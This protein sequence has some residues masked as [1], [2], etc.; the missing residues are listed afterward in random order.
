MKKI[1]AILLALIMASSVALVSCDDSSSTDDEGPADFDGAFVDEDDDEGDGSDEV[2]AEEDGD[3]ENAGN[4]SNSTTMENVNDTVYLLYPAKIREKASDK[5]SV[6]SLAN[7]PFG[8]TLA[9]TSK[10]SKWS[11]VTYTENGTSYT[12]YVPNDLIST[13][14]NSIKFDEKKNE[15]GSE[16]VTAIK[17]NLG[18]GI[19][20]A[21]IRKYPLANGTPNTFNVVDKDEFN[22]K[23]IV[24]QIA[25]NTQNITLVSVSADGVWAKVKGTGVVFENGA[26]TNPP[27]TEVIEGYTLYS[28]LVIAGSSSSSGNNGGDAW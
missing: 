13:N 3:D 17:A 28:N 11:K 14:A 16:I 4:T 6:A 5:E 15:D 26:P 22:T 24:G 19:N 20:N 23:S 7:A 10:N 2:D 12:G 25:K 27:K 1:L 8:A 21:I 18:N 9:R